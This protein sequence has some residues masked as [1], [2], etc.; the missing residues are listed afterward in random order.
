MK[1]KSHVKLPEFYYPVSTQGLE[2]ERVILYVI[3]FRTQDD[4]RTIATMHVKDQNKLLAC[5]DHRRMALGQS[6]SLASSSC[7]R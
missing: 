7:A 1:Y 5:W 4:Q 6:G 3:G 2:R